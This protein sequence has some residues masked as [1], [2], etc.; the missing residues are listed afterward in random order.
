[1]TEETKLETKEETKEELKLETETIMTTTT[2][3]EPKADSKKDELLRRLTFRNQEDKDKPLSSGI[4][5]AWTAWQG[6]DSEIFTEDMLIGLAIAGLAATY[7]QVRV[8][9]F[10]EALQ[11]GFGSVKQARYNC[12]ERLASGMYN[13]T[14]FLVEQLRSNPFL[15]ED[16]V[17]IPVVVQAIENSLLPAGKE[18]LQ[19]LR[20]REEEREEARRKFRAESEVLVA[21]VYDLTG[22]HPAIDGIAKTL[23]FAV[24]DHDYKAVVGAFGQDHLSTLPYAVGYQKGLYIAPNILETVAPS[25]EIEKIRQGYSATIAL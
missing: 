10:L 1:M 5:K 4:V 19:A 7:E 13:P 9:G 18:K 17:A 21:Q 15:R 20:L 25:G 24:K 8:D 22:K 3:E 23:R 16:L 11:G 2:L 12:A 14:R 6:V